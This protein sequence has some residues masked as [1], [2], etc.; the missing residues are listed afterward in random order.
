MNCVT[1]QGASD[2]QGDAL[3][4]EMRE[5]VRPTDTSRGYFQQIIVFQVIYIEQDFVEI[6]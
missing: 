2:A 5:T 3:Y 4:L 6:R 1:V